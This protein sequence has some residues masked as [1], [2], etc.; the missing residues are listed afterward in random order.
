M[1]SGIYEL[2]KNDP[3]T[4]SVPNLLSVSRLLFLPLICHFITLQTKTG[5]ILALLFLALSGATDFLD[6]YLARKL[7]QRS[8]LGR[9]LDP[10]LDKFT[11]GII[12]LYLAAYRHLPYWYVMLVIGRDLL[13]LIFA[14]RLVHRTKTM[15][16]SNH[17]GKWT[18]GSFLFVIT[19]YIINWNPLKSFALW[20]SLV[21]IPAT[22]IS[23]LI[24]SR[25]LIRIDHS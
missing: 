1:K 25:K 9:I 23:Y 14:V 15:A 4:M 2:L 5:S 16:E 12:M 19:T 6:G 11:V 13:I 21:L 8:D 7:D 18:L 10:L 17:L 3:H 22:L 20:V 24:S